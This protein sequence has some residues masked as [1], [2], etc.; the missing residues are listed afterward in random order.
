M[1]WGE[2]GFN[3]W[4]FK[5]PALVLF[6][7]YVNV[8]GMRPRSRLS[9]KPLTKPAPWVIPHVGWSIPVVSTLAELKRTTFSSLL[10]FRVFPPFLLS[11][12]PQTV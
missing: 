2:F 5:G 11:Y 10:L 4:G 12:L 1:G 6:L 8:S 7:I 3:C 9:T